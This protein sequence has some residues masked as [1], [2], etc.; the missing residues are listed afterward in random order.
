MIIKL[1]IQKKEME[2]C[3]FCKIVK[4]EIPCQ[5]VYEDEKVLAFN[6]INPLAPIHVLVV[7]KQHFDNVM[8][9]SEDRLDVITD[10]FKAINKIVKQLGIEEKGFRVVTNCGQDAGQ[11]VMHLHFHILAGK[12]LGEEIMKIKNAK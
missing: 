8:E 11:A 12:D 9:V 5:K 2:D 3:I 6:D 7:P 4:G 10:I 1:I